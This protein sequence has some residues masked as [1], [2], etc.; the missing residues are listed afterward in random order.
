MGL[1]ER[2]LAAAQRLR[3]DVCVVA[4]PGSG[5]TSVLIERFS[6]LVTSE[7]VSPGRILTITFTDKAATEIRDRL[8]RRFERDPERRVAIERAYVS[9]IH[10]FCARILR[11]N[12]IAAG[13]DPAFTVLEASR[14]A[15]RAVADEVLNGMYAEQPQRMR[16]FLRA[17]AVLTARDLQVPDL[18]TSLVEIYD[19]A[20]LA[21][22][23]AASIPAPDLRPMEALPKL[24]RLAAEIAKEDPRLT[25]DGQ[26]EHFGRARDWARTL[27]Q[28]VDV[29]V[30]LVRHV[31]TREKAHVRCLP[32]GSAAL[33]H[34]DEIRELCK[35]AEAELLAS[36]Y[37]ADAQTVVYALAELDRAYRSRKREASS[38]DFDDLEEQVIRLLEQDAALRSTLQQSFDH[39]LMDELQDTN[40]LQWQLI[41]LLRRP[42]RFFAV[43]DIN[44]SIY[45]FRH[46]KPEL[47]LEYRNSL[48]ASGLHVDELRDNYRSRPELL[49]AVNSVFRAAPGIEPHSLYAARDFAPAA[50]ECVE[51]IVALGEYTEEAERIE[52]AAI[53]QRIRELAGSLQLSTGLARY[54]DIAVLTRTNNSTAELQ[55]ALDRFGVPSVVVGG[56]TFYET[57][58]VRDLLLF[59][60]A[61]ANPLDEISVAGVLRSP[62]AGFSDEDLLRFSLKGSLLAGVLADKPE[63]LRTFWALREI[64]NQVSPDR[65]LRSALD[66]SGYELALSDR[67]RANVDKFLAIVREKFERQPASLNEL[68]GGLEDVPPDSEAPPPEYGNAVRLL[69]LHKA[70]GLEFPVVFLP[71]LHKGKGNGFPVVSY[72]HAFG[73]G[74]KWRNPVTSAGAGDPVWKQNQE[75]S[76]AAE[77][78]EENRL[79]YVGMTR[80]REHLVLSWCKARGSTSQWPAL[81]AAGLN[82]NVE[83]GASGPASQNGVRVLV[84]DRA[85]SP[86]ESAAAMARRETSAILDFGNTSEGTPSSASITDISQFVECPRRYYL[87]RF[88]GWDGVLGSAGNSSVEAAHSPAIRTALSAADLGHQVHALLAGTIVP[89]SCAEATELAD[90]FRTSDL[91]KRAAKAPQSGRE[92]ELTFEYGGIILRAQID[93]WF[94]TNRDLI[95]VDYKTDREVDDASLEAYALQVR[96]YAVALGRYLGRA[97]TRGIIF[98]LRRGQ[99]IEVDVTPLSLGA[100]ADT[101]HDFVQAAASARFPLRVGNH[102]QRCT[103]FRNQCPAS[104]TVAIAT[105]DNV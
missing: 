93:L 75:H 28:L 102:C 58:E 62:L 18:A 55:I 30:E 99:A 47:F 97:V 11:E 36:Y 49:A 5:K 53:A 4:G 38:L 51:A 83:S 10:A 33:A 68:L 74:I 59:L 34:E 50:M 46:A 20:R 76:I 40:P 14:S 29:D 23:D 87:S 37:A 80:A 6:T 15:L 13:V 2:Q 67:A 94:S 96:L 64:R 7:G 35:A 100:T 73:L 52:A 1:S 45:G 56:Q 54:A 19:A 42:R 43:G 90:R 101:L 79:L 48:T 85:R 31:S 57:R 16:S 44:Q 9:T 71:Y 92:W 86:E 98:L 81:L 84:V 39:I 103:W 72:T 91:G 78:G 104:L 8:V 69:T 89:D 63:T 105:S 21:G 3:Q 25:T 82:I 41:E 60:R 88:L 12:A 70:K 61:L 27:L 26:R 65:L 22:V 66:E 95:V 24:N 17:L 32:K 77:K